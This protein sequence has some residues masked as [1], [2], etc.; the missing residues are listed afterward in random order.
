MPLV[1]MEELLKNAVEKK[2][3]VGYFESWNM[4]SLLAVLEAAEEEKSP[5]I[6][7][8]GAILSDKEW[9][10]EGGMNI[11]ASSGLAAA[12]GASV[13]VSLIFNEATSFTQI[14]QAIR[15]GFNAVSMDS[16]HLSFESPLILL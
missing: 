5:V 3:I 2:Y 13:P 15:Y 10:E 11:L 14:I 9:L 1:S 7:G 16:S 8:F 12:E 4:E 6:I